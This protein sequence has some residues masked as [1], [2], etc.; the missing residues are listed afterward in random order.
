MTPIC[1]LSPASPLPSGGVGSGDREGPVLSVLPGGKASLFPGP[2]ELK[3]MAALTGVAMSVL[4]EWFAWTGVVSSVTVCG[5]MDDAKA[6]VG[7]MLLVN[8]RVPLVSPGPLLDPSSQETGSNGKAEDG[9]CLTME[10]GS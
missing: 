8:S 4:M 7:W 2:S 1:K 3:G 9:L 10:I 5:K 6:K